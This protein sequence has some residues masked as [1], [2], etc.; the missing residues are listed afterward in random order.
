MQI[1]FI[2]FIGL[3]LVACLYAFWRGGGPERAVAWIFIAAWVISITIRYVTD[4]VYQRPAWITLSVDTAVLIALAVVTRRANRA[5]PVVVT[6]MQLL[7]V[8]S[9]VARTIN[10]HQFPRVYIV[11]TKSWP[12]LQLITLLVGTILHWRRTVTHGAEDSWKN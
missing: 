2:A 9:H 3:L 1:L 6:S 5:W 11:M 7:I 8:L 12:Y 4:L 10:A